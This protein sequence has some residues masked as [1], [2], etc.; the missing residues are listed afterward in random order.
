[1]RPL[2]SYLFAPGNN[3]AL[4]GKVFGAGADAVVLDLEDGP[5]AWWPQGSS[6][7]HR[8]RSRTVPARHSFA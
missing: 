2:R 7:P 6:A 4:L 5:D 1:M 8:P 3:E